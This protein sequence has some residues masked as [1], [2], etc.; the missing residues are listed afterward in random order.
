MAR[1]RPNPPPARDGLCPSCVVVQQGAWATA[2]G[3]FAERFAGVD[4]AE[5]AERFAAGDVVDEQGTVVRETDLLHTGQRLYYFRSVPQEPHIPFYERILYQDADLV[6]VDKPHFLPVIPSGKYVHETVL[7][8]LGRTLNCDTLAPIHRID[9]DTAGIVLFSRN[10]ATR[11]AYHRLFREHV[12]TKTYHAIARWNPHL[13]WPITRHTRIAEGSHFMQQ[14]EVD[15]PPNART[16][17]RPLL[18]GDA[19]ALYELQPVNGQRHQLRVHMHALGLPILGDGIY[20][21]LTPEGSQ[22]FAHPLQLLA[23]SIAFT[24]PLSGAPRRY[25]STLQLSALPSIQNA[26]QSN[27][28]AGQPDQ[29]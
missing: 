6:V 13:P 9:R 21:V 11:N 15:G 2:L 4:R 5:W 18:H 27:S 16:T 12:V 22:D 1:Y 17:I 3:F 28:S 25:E 23:Q 20:P 29:A 24:D 10:P 8:R 26:T 14:A 19:L 7:V